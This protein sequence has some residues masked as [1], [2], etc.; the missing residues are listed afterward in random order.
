MQITL[1]SFKFIYVHLCSTISGDFYITLNGIDI[2]IN[3]NTGYQ[4]VL[5]HFED[6]IQSPSLVTMYISIML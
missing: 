6:L 3:F 1:S 5:N 2:G 4:S